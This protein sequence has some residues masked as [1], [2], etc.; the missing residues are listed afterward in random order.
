MVADARQTTDRAETEEWLRYLRGRPV[1]ALLGRVLGFVS[2]VVFLYD[3]KEIT[4]SHIS[5]M[6]PIVLKYTSNCILPSLVTWVVFTDL[7]ARYA[8]E[9]GASGQYIAKL[10]IQSGLILIAAA[11]IALLLK[12]SGAALAVSYI[13]CITCSAGAGFLGGMRLEKWR[14]PGVL[15][16]ERVVVDEEEEE[17]EEDAGSTRARR[18]VRGPEQ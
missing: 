8:A 6:D 7:G 11:L 2:V 9:R 4:E 18:E 16:S 5:V 17:E 3:L 15:R 13:G 12:N 14:A 1:Q 10:L